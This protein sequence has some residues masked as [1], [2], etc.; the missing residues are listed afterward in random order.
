MNPVEEYLAQL[1]AGLASYPEAK[2]KVSTLRGFFDMHAIQSLL[3]VSVQHSL[4]EDVPASNWV[5]EVHVTAAHIAMRAVSFESDDDYVAFARAH[6]YRLFSS[7]LYRGAFRLFRPGR[8]AR[9]LNSTWGLFHRGTSVRVL[10]Q[11]ESSISFVLTFPRRVWPGFVQRS[12][13]SGGEEAIR[14]GGTDNVKGRIVSR[15]ETQF[16]GVYE[17]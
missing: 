1:P 10:Q 5:P 14:V 13:F 17:W 2:A 8:L 4:A 11:T 16:R 7:P 9:L 6:N 15:S 12:L 3:P